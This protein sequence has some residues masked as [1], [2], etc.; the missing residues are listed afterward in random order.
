MSPSKRNSG[1]SPQRRAA[2]SA[3][4]K[5]L[6]ADPDFVVRRRKAQTEWSPERR[7]AKSAEFTARNHDPE[8]HKRK[9]AGIA[10]RP[11]R[12]FKIPERCHPCVRGLFVEMNEQKATRSEVGL[13]AGV[14]EET[15]SSWRGRSMPLLD[16]LDA[17]LNT[18]DLELAIVPIGTRDQNGFARRKGKS[19]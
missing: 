15:L 7:A 14:N 18:L 9:L 3:M 5:T 13:R 10:Q 8:F 12:G 6:N 16:V 4:M 11:R 19:S 1:W 17:V 2:Q